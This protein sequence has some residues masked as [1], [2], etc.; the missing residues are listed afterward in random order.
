[1]HFLYIAKLGC[2]TC[3]TVWKNH[4]F[5]LKEY[6]VLEINL[7][8]TSFEKPFFHEFFCKKGNV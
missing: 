2:I 8:L 7:L 3:K 4:E 6:I 1:M 5:T